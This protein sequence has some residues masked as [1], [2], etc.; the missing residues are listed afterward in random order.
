MYPLRSTWSHNSFP[1]DCLISSA[2][3]KYR[4]R[5]HRAGNGEESGLGIRAVGEYV[6]TE[7]AL[8]AI[9]DL[10]LTFAQGYHVGMPSP[11][12]V[13]GGRMPGLNLPKREDSVWKRILFP[14]GKAA[15][16]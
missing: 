1:A 5:N 10:G 16:G 3:G 7:E 13:V 2:I 15:S 6:E 11:E 12:L 14:N 8:Q 4:I 9:T